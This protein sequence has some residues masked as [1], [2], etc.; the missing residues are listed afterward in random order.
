MESYFD[1]NGN[2]IPLGYDFLVVK[3]K[4]LFKMDTADIINKANEIVP[5]IFESHFSFDELNALK[6]KIYCISKITR[7]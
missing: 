4:M 3:E 6:K 7:Q 1:F 5:N 2:E